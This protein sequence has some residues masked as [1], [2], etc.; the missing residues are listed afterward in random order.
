MP[1]R[2]LVSNIDVQASVIPVVHTATA[3]GTGIDLDG[4]DSAAIIVQ[5]GAIGSAGN[6]TAKIQESDVL[7]SGYTDVA[8]ADQVG[9]FLAV[10]LADTIEK[11]SYIGNKRYV[12]AMLTKNSGTSIA[13]GVLVVRG[14]LAQRPD[15]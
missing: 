10:M 6:F 3:T 14:N 11:V 1:N 4:C 2:D 13:A 8:A 15:A 12:R 7:G 5:S 9:T